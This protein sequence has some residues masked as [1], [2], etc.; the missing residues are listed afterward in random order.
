MNIKLLLIVTCLTCIYS[1]CYSQN[2]K[3]LSVKAEC[4]GFFTETVMNLDCDNFRR[5]FKE[6]MSVKSFASLQDVYQFNS[7]IKKF[8]KQEMPT[9][10]DI[11]G[12]MTLNYKKE[13]VKY[14]FDLFG[15]FYKDGKAYQ[16]TKLLSYIS[17]KLY[18]DHPQ[19]LDTLNLGKHEEEHKKSN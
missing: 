16:N 7:L 3:L 15:R 6:T 17:D 10:V 12:I 19:Y 5:Q 9:N 14:C 8:K 18:S 1:S 11:R 2:S 13:S 4:G